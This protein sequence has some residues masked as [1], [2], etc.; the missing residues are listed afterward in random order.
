MIITSK[1]EKLQNMKTF[2]TYPRL[3]HNNLTK[4]LQQHLAYKLIY[5]SNKLLFQRM[6]V[7]VKVIGLFERNYTIKNKI[8]QRIVPLITRIPNKI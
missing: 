7:V 3:G 4:K 8:H 2:H 6:L 1:N 5:Y